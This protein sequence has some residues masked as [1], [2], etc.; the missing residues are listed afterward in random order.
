MATLGGAFILGGLAFKAAFVPF[1]QWSPDVYTGAP[2]P[3]TAFMSVVVKAAAFAALVRIFAT[4][5]PD[6]NS[7]L[8][9]GLAILV[10]LTLVVGNFVALVQTSLK[11]LLA[12]S[13]VAHAGY[14]GLALLAADGSGTQA[15]VW[16]L[17]AYTLMNAGAF[18][19]LSLLTD[20]NDRG[21]DL[22]RLAGLGKTRP[23]SSLRAGALSLITRRDSA[24]RRVSLEKSWCF[25]RR[26]KQAISA[27]PSSPS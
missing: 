4:V 17:T 23:Y 3:V 20:R 15:V 1:H 14:L 2:T 11:R 26:C 9:Q 24:A 21:D 13:A 12:Y 25:K 8:L 5:Y 22:E 6:L 10:A 18:A 16:Y 19:V 7:S 27:S